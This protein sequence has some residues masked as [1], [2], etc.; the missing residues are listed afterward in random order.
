MSS[1]Q[2]QRI[3]E[4]VPYDANWPLRFVQEAEIIKKALGY[5]CIEIHHVGS[6]SVP[7]LAAKPK[8]DIISVVKNLSFS[9]DKLEQ[10]GYLFRGGFNIPFRKSFTI[11]TALRNINLHVFEQNDPEIELNL[12]FRDYLRANSKEKKDYEDLKYNLIA[13]ESAHLKIGSIYNGYTLGKHCFIQEVLKK[14]GF[15]KMRF[16]LC[17]HHLEWE[18]AK[19]FRQKYF[20]G[21]HGID[22]P[23]TWTFNHNA[24]IHFVLYLC[25]EIIGYA[26]LQLWP[27]ERAALRIIVIDKPKRNHQYGSQ[28]LAVC[29]KWLKNQGCQSLHVESSPDALKFYR[30]NGYID[31]PFDDPDGYESDSRDTAVGKIL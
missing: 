5:N 24:H 28:F 12:F 2:E 7:G 17:T 22:D 26:H 3:I 16:V 1:K 8:I 6:T 13:E 9:N 18:A 25:C 27:K 29:E 19:N 4:V 31:M 20:F 23:Y 15:N 11:R 14:A 30:N 21:P 10:L